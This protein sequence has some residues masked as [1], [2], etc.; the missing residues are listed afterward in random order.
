MTLLIYS[1][2]PEQLKKDL[3]RFYGVR[4]SRINMEGR[5][6]VFRIRFVGLDMPVKNGFAWFDGRMYELANEI[7]AWYWKQRT[8]ERYIVREDMLIEKE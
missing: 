6:D 7:A 4:G 5:D 8:A 1:E 3:M 2:N